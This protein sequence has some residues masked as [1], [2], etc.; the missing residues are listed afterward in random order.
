[1]NVWK[2]LIDVQSMQYVTTI[3]E[4][5]HVTVR[6]GSLEMDFFALVGADFLYHKR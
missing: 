5:T 3:L 4:T 1:M 2:E 6:K